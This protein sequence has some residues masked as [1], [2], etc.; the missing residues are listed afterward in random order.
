MSDRTVQRF[1]RLAAQV[2]ERPPNLGP[3]RLIAVDG[4]GGAGKSAFAGRLAIAL[5]GAPVIHTDDLAAED[6][7]FDWWSRLEAEVL[8]PLSSGDPARFR[9]TDWVRGGLQASSVTVPVEEVVVLEGVSASRASL[10]ARLSAAVWVDAPAGTRLE[11]GL[12][13]DGEDART[14]WKRWMREESDF[15]ATDRPWA[16]ADLLVDGAPD[17]RRYPHDPDQAFVARRG[18]G[19]RLA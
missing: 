18:P 3:V 5:D 13:R 1:D 2:R 9:P 7:E 6:V 19:H 16:R 4:P 11:R 8:G 17:H 10:A 14:R 12:E 15:F